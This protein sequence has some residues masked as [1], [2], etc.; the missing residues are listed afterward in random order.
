MHFSPC[1][2]A[3]HQPSDSRYQHRPSEETGERSGV[4]HPKLMGY[5]HRGPRGRRGGNADRTKETFQD[6]GDKVVEA[7][8]VKG[9]IG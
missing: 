7:R 6:G 1:R 4:L 9:G 3:L 5:F 2:R 8:E